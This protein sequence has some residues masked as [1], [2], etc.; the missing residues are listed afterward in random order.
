MNVTPEELRV[1]A[2]IIDPPTLK[3]GEQG[4]QKSIVSLV[5]IKLNHSYS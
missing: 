4:R 1:N 3:Y 2:R 5:S